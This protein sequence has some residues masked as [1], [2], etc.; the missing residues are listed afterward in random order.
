MY[1]RRNREWRAY[2][3]SYEELASFS[4][5]GE[6]K[7]RKAVK[8]LVKRKLVKVERQGVY[9]LKRGGKLL[10]LPASLATAVLTYKER[11]YLSLT[12]S[13]KDTQGDGDSA[14]ISLHDI[15]RLTGESKWTVHKTLKDLTSKGLVSK[16]FHG[17]ILRITPLF[18]ILS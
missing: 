16:D 18:P 5:M 14:I 10:S 8:E 2:F 17:R 3:R 4:G 9:L 7:A 13:L 12:W 1:H 11:A 6:E 15:M